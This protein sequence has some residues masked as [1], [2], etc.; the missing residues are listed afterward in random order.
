MKY[1]YNDREKEEMLKNEI[2]EE[3]IAHIGIVKGLTY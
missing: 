3:D 2:K 1:A